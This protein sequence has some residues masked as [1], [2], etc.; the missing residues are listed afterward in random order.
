MDNGSV[1]SQSARTWM[2][3]L[4]RTNTFNILHH[5]DFYLFAFY[6]VYLLSQAICACS[7]CWKKEYKA[8]KFKLKCLIVCLFF[9]MFGWG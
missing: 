8:Y 5:L 4:N 3:P 2:V 6:V 1:P 7:L 9:Q